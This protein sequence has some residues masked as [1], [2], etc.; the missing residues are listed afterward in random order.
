MVIKKKLLVGKIL[1]PI[2]MIIFTILAF[3][4]A[5]LFNDRVMVPYVQFGYY[6]RFILLGHLLLDIYTLLGIKYK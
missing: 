1:F 6:V 5:M 4:C 2:M 3:I